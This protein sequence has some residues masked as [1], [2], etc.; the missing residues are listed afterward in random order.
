MPQAAQFG[1]D[2]AEHGV[3][4]MTSEAGVIL[5]DPIV[6]KMR[7]GHVG[8]IV[9]VQALAMGLHDVARQAKVRRCRVLQVN[10]GAHDGRDNRQD[11]KRQE[12][13]DLT[14]LR[15]RDRR[16]QH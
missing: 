3:V 9:D 10:R 11:K 5:G 1:I 7:G 15:R 13:D 16:P 8:R 4:G 2:V 14:A 6:L 12:S